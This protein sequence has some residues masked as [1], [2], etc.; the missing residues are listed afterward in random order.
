M[1]SIKHDSRKVCARA[2][3]VQFAPVYRITLAGRILKLRE[4]GHL[5]LIP[6]RRRPSA[7]STAIMSKYSDPIP[8]TEVSTVSIAD[9]N[10]RVVVPIAPS[11]PAFVVTAY[12]DEHAPRK[13]CDRPQVDARVASKL[14][15]SSV[16]MTITTTHGAVSH[17]CTAVLLSERKYRRTLLARSLVVSLR[18]SPCYPS[19]RDKHMLLGKSFGKER[20]DN[21]LTG[22]QGL[23]KEDNA[24]KVSD[25]GGSRSDLTAFLMY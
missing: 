23:R 19:S 20:E 14:Q 24:A 21:L 17:G 2:L 8:V 1:L 3:F 13:L 22:R 18:P 12:G 25:K 16:W 6:S 15:R 10:A 5:S 11:G 7:S 9:C 4:D